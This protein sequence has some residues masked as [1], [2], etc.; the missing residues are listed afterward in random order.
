MEQIQ[1]SLK[2]LQSLPNSTTLSVQQIAKTE[3]IIKGQL[4]SL[5][6]SKDKLLVVE[7][8]YQQLLKRTKTKE[9][10]DR[11]DKIQPYT[12]VLDQELRILETTVAILA[13]NEQYR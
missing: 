9:L 6:T 13:E 7:R 8:Q 12:E 4:K 10:V 3:T 5:E 1:K 11:L 2:S